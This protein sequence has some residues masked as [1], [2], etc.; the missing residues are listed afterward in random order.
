[1][2]NV[3]VGS[4]CA[5]SVFMFCFRGYDRRDRIT[6]IFCSICVFGVAFF[7]TVPDSGA[8]EH[9]RHLAIAHYTFATLL[10]SALVYF[11][12]VLFKLAEPGRKMTRRK[13]QRN[14]V[15]TICGCAIILSMLGIAVLKGLDLLGLAH[16]EGI[17]VHFR[18][19]FWFESTAMI[20]FGVAWLAKGQAF[21]KDEEPDGPKA[22][23]RA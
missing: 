12:F 20:A 11:C 19:T 9:Q 8:T 3:L 14:R 13:L 4:L 2:R 22:A 16:F 7:P 18:T 23:D 15:Y 21:L 1:M 10:F 6:G 17:V 5:I